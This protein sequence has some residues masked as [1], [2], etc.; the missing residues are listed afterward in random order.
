MV[1]RRRLLEALRCASSRARQAGHLPAAGPTTSPAHQLAAT[2]FC[3]VTAFRPTTARATLAV[4]FRRR[5]SS[6]NARTARRK[7]DA[8]GG[9]PQQNILSPRRSSVPCRFFTPAQPEWLLKLDPH[10]IS[11]CEQPRLPPVARP[12]RQ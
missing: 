10:G 7:N 4:R 12:H 9:G 5:V 6:A 11:V 2:Y 1:R 8:Y 3:Q